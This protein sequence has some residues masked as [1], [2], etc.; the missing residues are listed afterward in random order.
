MI[1]YIK[2]GCHQMNGADEREKIFEKI[3][4]NLEIVMEKEINKDDIKLDDCFGIKN[5]VLSS[6]DYIM[7]IVG[8]EK[9]M[10]VKFPDEELDFHNIKKVSDLVELTYDLLFR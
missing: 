2:K 8:L 5:L 1:C 6:Y 4:Y 7:L 10:D 9:D 3:K